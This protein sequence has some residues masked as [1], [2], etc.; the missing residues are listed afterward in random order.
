MSDI[1]KRVSDI[2]IIPVIA[3]NSVEEAVPQIGRAHV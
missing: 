1:L 2:G 3:F